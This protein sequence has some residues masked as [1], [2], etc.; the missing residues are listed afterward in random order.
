LQ[1]YAR[2]PKDNV[3]VVPNGEGQN[4]RSALV[5][6]AALDASL[7]LFSAMDRNPELINHPDLADVYPRLKRISQAEQ[8]IRKN[9]VIV[10]PG[11]GSASNSSYASSGP[12][13]SPLARELMKPKGES[14]T[15]RELG[16]SD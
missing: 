2:V 13:V 12:H 10:V 5:I 7:I 9:V 6:K 1:E 8:F 16:G 14:C 3:A 11:Q 4:Q 15:F